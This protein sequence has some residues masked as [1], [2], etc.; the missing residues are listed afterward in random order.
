MSFADL[1][2]NRT[3]LGK[4]V[5][6][7]TGDEQKTESRSDDRF[8]NPTRDKAGNGY[9]VIR[10][11]PGNADAPTPWVRY[12]DHFFKG[13]T[14]QWYVEKSLTSI[15]KPDPLSEANSKL[16]NEDGSEE[17]KRIVRERKRNLRHV[18]NV[19][20]LSDPS[21]PENEGKVKLYRFGKKIFDKIMDSLQPQFPDEAPMNPFD[22][23]DGADF[24]VK[25]RNVEGYAN[26][27][28]SS[29]KAPSELYAGD[30][31]A[32]ENVY[33]QQ[34]DLSE[35][36]EAENYKSYDELKNRLAIVLGESTP[37]TRQQIEDLDDEIPAF[38]NRSAAAPS[39]PAAPEPQITTAESSMDDD[40]TM[41]YFSKLAAE[42]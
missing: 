25:I 10:F 24:V 15:G 38:E 35:W 9:A 14:G 33:N 4:L 23:W 7:A 39:A 41:A 31:D 8:W 3:D 1:K 28:A 26:Y 13:P 27:D 20:I 5:A 30:D 6:A 16:W 21:N 32:K 18:A 17:A 2:R 40:D 22:M 11:L 42:G 37:R 12:W 19:L 36:S 34:H 29:F